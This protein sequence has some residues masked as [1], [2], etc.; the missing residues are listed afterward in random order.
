L[1]KKSYRGNRWASRVPL[2]AEVPCKVRKI[3]GVRA[4]GIIWNSSTDLSRAM[5][6]QDLTNADLKDEEGNGLPLT[7]RYGTQEEPL[8]VYSNI[9]SRNV[10]L[11]GSMAW[12]RNV[13]IN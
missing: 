3:Y 9:T 6:A 4:G 10:Y 1:Y 11:G 5:K 7:H 13:A 2:N 8:N 12:V